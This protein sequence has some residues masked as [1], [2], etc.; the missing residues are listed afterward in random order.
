MKKQTW[1]GR[2]AK[3]MVAEATLRLALSEIEAARATGGPASTPTYHYTV[4][5][6]LAQHAADQLRLA[7]A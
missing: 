6:H 7:D 2:A 4:A 1:Q 5:K 3:R